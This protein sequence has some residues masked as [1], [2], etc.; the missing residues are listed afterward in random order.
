MTQTPTS[1][2]RTLAGLAHASILLGMLTNGLGG[3]VAATL[4]WATQKDRSDYVAFQALQA[5]VYMLVSIAVFSLIW[6]CWILF[7][8]ATWIPMFSALNQ[9]P[10]TLPLSF[11]VGILSMALPFLVMGL[12]TLYGLWGAL[13]CFQGRDFR[14]LVIG[15]WVQRYLSHEEQA[16]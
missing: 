6:C 12:W 14:Y 3:A 15:D 10:D 2:E 13:R 9:D 16:V 8:F 1:N 11:W 5:A 4:I 7:Y